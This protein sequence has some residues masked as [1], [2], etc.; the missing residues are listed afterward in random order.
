M[1]R[2]GWLG[3]TLVGVGAAVAVAGAWYMVHARPVAGDVIG[4]VHVDPHRSLVIR[5]EAKGP[6]AFVELRDGDTVKWQALVPEYAGRPDA[7][8]VAWSPVAVSVRVIRDGHAEVF[9]LSEHDSSKLGG[10]R[11]APEHPDPVIIQQTGPVTLTDHVRSYELVAGRD[12]HQLVAIDLRTG[13]GVW[14]RELGAAEITAG[15]VQGEQVWIEQ[16]GKRRA[17]AATTGADEDPNRYSKFQ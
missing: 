5:R 10:L 11:L 12:W 6:R 7:P 2:L 17:F 3:P 14:S 8:G 1:T 13:K 15:G 9:A 4:E 16:A